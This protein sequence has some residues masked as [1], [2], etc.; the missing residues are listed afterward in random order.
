[1]RLVFADGE[2]H[3]VL[4]QSVKPSRNL[5]V[6]YG[7]LTIPRPAD[8]RGPKS[9]TLV[10]EL[11]YGGALLDRK[12]AEIDLTET[13]KDERLTLSLA[14]IPRFAAPDELVN[15]AVGVNN[16]SREDTRCRLSLYLDSVT[17]TKQLLN[18]DLELGPEQERTLG[19]PLRVP[20]AAEMSTAEL[21]AIA[22]RGRQT[23]ETRQVFKVKAIEQALFHIDFSVKN[24]R[25]EEIRGLVPRHSPVDITVRLTCP[26]SGIEGIEVVLRIMSRREVVKEFRIPVI[27][28]G[29]VG[30]EHAVKWN[31]P[32]VDLVTGYYTDASILA[33]GKAL[34]SRAVETAQ[35][36]FTV[37]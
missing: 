7:P 31:T 12:S 22:E 6:A 33:D 19:V 8:M 29:G 32:V 26:R 35:R 16:N 23:Y 20:L 30:F 18:Q 9:V 34:P 3:T 37:Y 5:S 11:Q 4:S 36:Q 2:E 27:T 15:L 10:A 28:S 1:M 17:G 13:A 25:G 14:G 21:R 24:E